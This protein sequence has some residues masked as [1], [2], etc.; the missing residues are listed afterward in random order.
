M[1]EAVKLALRLTTSAYDAEIQS[2]IDAA[3]ADLGIAG[4]KQDV[5]VETGTDPLIKRAVITYVRLHFGTP[6]DFDN[7]LK[8]YFEQKGQLQVATNYTDWGVL[9]D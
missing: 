1:L 4:I 7:L 5:L 9:N 8:S 2:L 3:L 6:D